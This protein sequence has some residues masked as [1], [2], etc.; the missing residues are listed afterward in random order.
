M[1]NYIMP[2]LSGNG[3]SV[4]QNLNPNHHPQQ[5][6]HVEHL[7]QHAKNLS[8]NRISRQVALEHEA[9]LR[10]LPSSSGRAARATEAGL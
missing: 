1:Y 5:E 3:D 2:M 7:A 4:Q 6:L 10:L 9:V 8:G